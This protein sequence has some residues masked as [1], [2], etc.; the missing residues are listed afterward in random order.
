MLFSWGLLL[1]LNGSW[2]GFMGLLLSG[3]VPSEVNC[4]AKTRHICGKAFKTLQQ[5]ILQCIWVGWRNN[6]HCKTTKVKAKLVQYASSH[7]KTPKPS[8]SLTGEKKLP[9]QTLFSMP[10]KHTFNPPPKKKKRQT[11]ALPSPDP[12]NPNRH[13]QGAMAGGGSPNSFSSSLSSEKGRWAMRKRG[14]SLGRG[15]SEFGGEDL[16]EKKGCCFKNYVL[17]KM[18]LFRNKRPFSLALCALILGVSL[19][20]QGFSS[21]ISFIFQDDWTSKGLF[22][23]KEPLTLEPPLGPL[24]PILWPRPRPRGPGGHIRQGVGNGGWLGG[25]VCFSLYVLFLGRLGWS[26]FDLCWSRSTV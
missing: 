25:W 2:N 7:H 14:S 23:R 15:K 20:F 5:T 11:P 16:F 26:G 6:D 24:V 9:P 3:L 18:F 8:N 10:K 13:H 12:P 22:Q 19:F 17:L 1:I 4:K 21:S